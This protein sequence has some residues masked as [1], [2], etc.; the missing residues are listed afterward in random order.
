MGSHGDLLPLLLLLLCAFSS[1]AAAAPG[2]G[3]NGLARTPCVTLLP[4]CLAGC[5]SWVARC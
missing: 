2:P 5:L 4:A 3:P 1:R